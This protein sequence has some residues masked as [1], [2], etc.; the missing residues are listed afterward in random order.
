MNKNLLRLADFPGPDLLLAY[1]LVVE[2]AKKN[3]RA[4]LADNASLTFQELKF[5]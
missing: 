1:N 3:I 5:K 4:S 2:D